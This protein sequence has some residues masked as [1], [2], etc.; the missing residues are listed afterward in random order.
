[1]PTYLDQLAEMFHGTTIDG[2][3]SCIPGESADPADINLDE[4]DDDDVT[5]KSPMSTS[6]KKRGSSTTDIASSPPKKHKSPMVKCMKGLIGTIQAGNSSDVVVAK[7]IQDHMSNL[8]K[9][10]KRLEE[11]QVE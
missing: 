2:R 9:K 8:K 10:E 6:S 7:Q 1:M 3:S 4:D 5:F 11:Q